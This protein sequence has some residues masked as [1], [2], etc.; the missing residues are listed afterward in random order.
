MD[1]FVRFVDELSLWVGHA[2]AW[3]IVILTLGITYEVIVRYA[4]NDPTIWAFDISYMMYGAL[5]FMAGPYALSH[6]SHVRV[7]IVWRRWAPRTQARLDLVLYLVFFFPGVLALLY[8]GLS[9]AEQSWRYREVSVFSPAGIPIYP[10]KTLLPLGSA[11]LALQ[12]VAEVCRCLI[13]LRDGSWPRR[14]HDAEELDQVI[15]KQHMQQ[16]QEPEV[17]T[18]FADVIAG[19]GVTSAGG[20]GSVAG[21]GRPR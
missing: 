10:L 12:G 9:H 21:A 11:L 17:A 2:F 6:G 16:I 1:G 7:D 13:C 19:G 4:F 20:G 14:L 8:A 3:C 5:F 18:A 15:L